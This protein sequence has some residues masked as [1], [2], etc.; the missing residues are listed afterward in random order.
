MLKIKDLDSLL[1][2]VESLVK[3]KYMVKIITI[4]QEFPRENSIDYYQVNYQLIEKV[5]NNE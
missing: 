1:K 4:Y 5:D 2:I 3:N